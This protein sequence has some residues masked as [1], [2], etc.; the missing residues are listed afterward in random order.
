MLTMTDRREVLANATSANVLTGK[1]HEFVPFSSVVSLYATAEAIGLN[2]S[3]L[4]GGVAIVDDQ[5]VNAQNRMPITPDDYVA[6]TICRGGERLLLRF[7]NTSGG[8][9][10]AFSRVEINPI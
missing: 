3:F 1:S 6:Q 7:R 2:A 4:V 9:I 8:A 10:D 5:E